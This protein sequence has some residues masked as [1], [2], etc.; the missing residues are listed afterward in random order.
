MEPDKPSFCGQRLWQ[1]GC[2][3]LIVGWLVDWL[4]S[5]HCLSKKNHHIPPHQFCTEKRFN[6]LIFNCMIYHEIV[7]IREICVNF[8]L[9]DEESKSKQH[10][11]RWSLTLPGAEGKPTIPHLGKVDQ[12]F[13]QYFLKI[14]PKHSS[15]SPHY[16][17]LML[18]LFCIFFPR[19]QLSLCF[20]NY[21]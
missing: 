3:L 4:L 21:R 20:P 13:G 7:R 1:V 9:R 16:I 2:F 10:N 17:F 12:N 5:S 19:I 15:L 8:N 18:A 6:H 14:S 11:T